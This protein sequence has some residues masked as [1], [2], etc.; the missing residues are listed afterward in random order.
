MKG[1]EPGQS[2]AVSDVG[3]N[4]FT[5]FDPDWVFKDS[6]TPYVAFVAHPAATEKRLFDLSRHKAWILERFSELFVGK[7]VFTN[8]DIELN[9]FTVYHAEDINSDKVQVLRFYDN[10]VFAF[11]DSSWAMR[12]EWKGVF[13]PES[14]RLFIPG[15]MR[16]ASDYYNNCLDF[17][18]RVRIMLHVVNVAGCKRKTSAPAG[19]TP[20][21]FTYDGDICSTLNV[22]PGEMI[23]RESKRFLYNQ[24]ISQSNLDLEIWGLD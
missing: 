24:I 18:S 1:F 6:T 20:Q 19:Q 21:A 11:A 14:I 13:Y 5:L 2:P 4:F 9:C 22:F 8:E 17:K 3:I 16:F 23:S 10:G 15:V 7:P 12:P